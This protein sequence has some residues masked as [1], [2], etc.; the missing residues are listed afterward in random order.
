MGAF[1][2]LLIVYGTS[3]GESIVNAIDRYIDPK[4]G[5]RGK[6]NSHYYMFG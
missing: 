4:L 5:Y 2:F 6:R 3:V 1:D